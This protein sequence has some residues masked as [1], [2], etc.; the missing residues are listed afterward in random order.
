[1]LFE[2]GLILVL[3]KAV[4]GI[5]V[6]AIWNEIESES[7]RFPFLGDADIFLDEGNEF[8]SLIWPYFYTE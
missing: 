8:L 7:S 2:S 6:P 5:H 4:E 1:M 3:L